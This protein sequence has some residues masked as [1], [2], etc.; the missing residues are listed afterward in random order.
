[1]CEKHA[2]LDQA[3]NAWPLI[4]ALGLKMESKKKEIE[5][6]L[7]SRIIIGL[8]ALFLGIILWLRY[9]LDYE[10]IYQL[11]GSIFGFVIAGAVLLPK[12]INRI[13]GFIVALGI[14]VLATWFYYENHQ[15]PYPKNSPLR[16]A[17]VFGIPSLLY[18]LNTEIPII[19]KSIT[20]LIGIKNLTKRSS[21]TNNP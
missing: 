3:N 1:M 19:N 5:F 10:N 20:N 15:N 21:G 4:K 14:L 17:L 2:H 13:F 16:F 7:G 6:S 18:I 11:Y 12:P 8:F 9:S